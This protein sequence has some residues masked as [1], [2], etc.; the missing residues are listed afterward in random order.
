MEIE[1][2]VTA[3]NRSY[4]YGFLS[5]VYLQEPTREFIKSFRESNL[6]DVLNKSDLLFNRTINNDVSDKHLNNLVLEYTRL[7]IGPGKHISPYESVYRDNE[8]A[9]WSETTVEVKDFIESLGLEYSYNWSGLPDHIGVELE[10]MQR[11]TCH[12]KE[13]WTQEDKKQAIHCLE[14]EKRF[15]DEHLSQ[16][17]PTFCDKVKE[18]TRVAFYGEI[19][20]LTRQFIDFDSKLIDKNL[21]IM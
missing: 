12:E 6:L 13:A 14:F 1:M 5:I 2:D 21:E 8:D 18:E 20:D 19:A 9:L 17:V 10:F 7:F 15:V 11:L 16:W 3:E 4:S